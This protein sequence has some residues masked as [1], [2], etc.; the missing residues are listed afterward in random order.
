MSITKQQ[1]VEQ[2]CKLLADGTGVRIYG[3]ASRTVTAADRKAAES[4][5]VE[6]LEAALL[7]LEKEKVR[8]A[9]ANSPEVQQINEARRREQE[10]F[11]RDSEWSKIFRTPL[12]GNKVAV[13]NQ[14]NRA[15]IEGWLHP[16]ESLTQAVFA[17]AIADT[18]RLMS[19]LVVTSSD[20]LDPK[21][22]RQA[23]TAQADQDKQ[24]FQAF[25]RA[26]GFS[27]NEANWSLTR[28]VLGSGFNQYQLEQAVTSNGLRLARASQ[29][30]L[31]QYSQDAAEARQDYLK[32]QASPAELREA[33]NRE[34][35]QLR[36]QAQRQQV[37]AQVQAREQLDAQ[38][39]YPALPTET[40]DGVKLDSLFF[41]RLADTDI[42]KFKQYCTRYGFAAI[43]ARLN[44]VR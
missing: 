37:E 3:P 32:N 24:V 29:Q 17:K 23:A 22:Q 13:D 21:K 39:G 30:E 42:K 11:V 34:S 41:K 38:Q 26:N 44:G 2:V 43:T 36:I 5:T 20:S 40:S 7:Q 10:E 18:P 27:E 19:Q 28:S 1:L 14:A 16:H 9:A 35:E 8:I 4:K 33:A 31:A 15:A 6:F 12:P 25:V